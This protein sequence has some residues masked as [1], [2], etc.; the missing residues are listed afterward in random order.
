MTEDD[1]HK[2]SFPAPGLR[3][4]HSLAEAMEGYRERRRRE[5]REGE[6]RGKERGGKEEPPGHSKNGFRE[7]VAILLPVALKTFSVPT[8]FIKHFVS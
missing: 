1:C 7:D 8:G 5:E 2:A 6:R 3:V 4:P